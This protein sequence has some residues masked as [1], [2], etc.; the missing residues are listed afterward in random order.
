MAKKLKAT[1]PT[2]ATGQVW[3]EKT[4]HASETWVVVSI[5]ENGLIG[6]SGPGPCRAYETV[7]DDV[8]LRDWERVIS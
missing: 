7:V 5:S 3:K 2:I 4:A 6:L 8:L 1:H